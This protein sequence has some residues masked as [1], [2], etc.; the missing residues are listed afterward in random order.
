[1]A[2]EA[3]GIAKVSFHLAIGEFSWGY[4]K[5]FFQANQALIAQMKSRDFERWKRPQEFS[6]GW[7]LPL[8]IYVANEALKFDP[9]LP[10]KKTIRWVAPSPGKAVGF[11]FLLVPNDTPDDPYEN[12]ADLELIIRANLPDHHESLLLYAHHIDAEIV[13]RSANKSIIQFTAQNPGLPLPE[14]HRLYAEVDVPEPVTGS[15]NLLEVPTYADLFARRS[16]D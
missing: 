15:R 8:R 16:G 7:T 13:S 11:I 4:T 2:V 14:R 12:I 10:T 3:G 6:P 1:M 5:E 9:H